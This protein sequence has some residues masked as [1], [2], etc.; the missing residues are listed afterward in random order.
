MTN[1]GHEIPKEINDERLILIKLY[2]Y[3]KCPVCN[4][5]NTLT[6][7]IDETYPHG[8]NQGIHIFQ[9][10]ECGIIAREYVNY[11][12][13]NPSIYWYRCNKMEE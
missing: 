5:T 13:E 6:L 8:F 7:I 3:K 9:C 11:I 2:D 4:K 10:D 1:Y 12:G